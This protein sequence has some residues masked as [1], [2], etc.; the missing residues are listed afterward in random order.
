MRPI[1]I[2]GT[3][4]IAI[5]AHKERGDDESEIQPHY[6]NKQSAAVGAKRR[7]DG[8]AALA[9]RPNQSDCH[10]YYYYY[11]DRSLAPLI[12]RSFIKA[13]PTRHVY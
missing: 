4:P 6:G 11:T 8:A 9:G 13:E 5:M 7:G 2:V 12:R 10:F 1:G 3:G